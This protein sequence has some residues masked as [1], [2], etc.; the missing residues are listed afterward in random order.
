MWDHVPASTSQ[1]S[2][3]PVSGLL[4]KIKEMIGN[5]VIQYC[6]RGSRLRL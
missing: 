2:H 4:S 3:I 6:G 1:D 5:R